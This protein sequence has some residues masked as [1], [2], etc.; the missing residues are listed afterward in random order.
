MGSKD[1]VEEISVYFGTHV[2][3]YNIRNG[4]YGIILTLSFVYTLS[5]F[6]YFYPTFVHN[7]RKRAPSPRDLFASAYGN[8]YT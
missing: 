3:W 8:M 6:A 4:L 5:D 7:F 2:E 1:N